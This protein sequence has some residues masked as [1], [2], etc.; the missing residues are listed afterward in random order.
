M[1][2]CKVYDVPVP[3]TLEEIYKAHEVTTKDLDVKIEER[4]LHFMQKYCLKWDS[5]I[6][7]RL[8]FNE[9]EISDIKMRSNDGEDQ[10][11]HFLR[12]WMKKAPSATYHKLLEVLCELDC[13]GEVDEAVKKLVKILSKE[14]IGT[15]LLVG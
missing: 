7:Q 13:R 5:H 1:D 11:M 14:N 8:N 12:R 4:H 9:A 6:S 2:N 3:P 10:R 15:Y